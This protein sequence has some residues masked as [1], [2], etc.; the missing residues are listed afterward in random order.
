VEKLPRP[1]SG[2][3]ET[4]RGEPM[5]EKERLLSALFPPEG[6]AE[7]INLKFFVL[8]HSIT[9]EELCRE[10]ADAVEEHRSERAL[11]VDDIDAY[12]RNKDH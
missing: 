12:I 9:E 8:D 11:K 6:G 5:R 4:R 7:L 2:N 3:N 1:D 10:F